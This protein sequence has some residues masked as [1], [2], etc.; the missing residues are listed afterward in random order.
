MWCGLRRKL[1]EGGVI[2]LIV[3]EIVEVHSA[4][5]QGLFFITYMLVYLGVRVANRLL[6]IPDLS[7]YVT[8]TVFVSLLWKLAGLF[9]MHLYGSGTH[10]WRHTL[11][12]MFPDAVVEAIAAYWIYRWLEKFDQL[13]DRGEASSLPEDELGF[14]G[15]SF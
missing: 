5:P 1:L 4:S 3:S 2:T 7:S 11:V 14:E 9:V 8:A 10:P 15:E 12:F 13:T 6:V